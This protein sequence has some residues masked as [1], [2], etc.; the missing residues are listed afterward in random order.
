MHTSN[1]DNTEYVDCKNCGM[2]AVCQPI[3]AGNQSLSLSES[4]LNKKLA[5][6]ACETVFINETQL[7]C[8]YAVCSGTFKLCQ[9]TSIGEE[10]IIG[11]R[12]PGELLGEDAIYHEKYNYTPIAIGQG[13]LC[14]VLVNEVKTCSGMVPH[15]QQNLILLLAN[16]SFVNQ[17][18]N[19]SLVGKKT[20][21]SLLAAFLINTYERTIEHYKCVNEINL[22]MSRY[23]I[24]NF[25]GLRRETLSRLFSKLQKDSL[26]ST[27]GKK[28]IL[29]NID[30][31]RNLA[32]F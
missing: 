13:S 30:A 28:V 19:Q 24:A 15:L 25:L 27:K 4:Y 17:K 32:E 12:F 20:A 6:N 16:Q 10:R 11:F 8:I 23:D 22:V 5:I 3:N 1:K 2:N 9:Q 31:L 26:I 21:E 18:N 29:I 14:Q 7:T